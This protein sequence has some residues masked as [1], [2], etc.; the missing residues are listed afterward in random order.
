MPDSIAAGLEWLSVDQ[1]TRDTARQP[2]QYLL[3]LGGRLLFGK[4]CGSERKAAMNYTAKTLKWGMN[5]S[6]SFGRP[7][8][9]SWR[10]CT[11]PWLE[12]ST[13]TLV[14][15]PQAGQPSR[16]DCTCWPN[17]TALNLTLS[18]GEEGTNSASHRWRFQL[19]AVAPSTLPRSARGLCLQH[20]PWRFYFLHN[21]TLLKFWQI[22][23]RDLHFLKFFH[24]HEAT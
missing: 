22:T 13:Q 11:F 3:Q 1:E 4:P 18:Q 10:S 24:F 15:A 5:S 17:H 19:L 7:L 9:S 14:K 20:L 6:A 2:E 21:K 23:E 12:Q 16:R 8:D